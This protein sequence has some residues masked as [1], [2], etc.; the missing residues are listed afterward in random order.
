M[1]SRSDTARKTGNQM[2]GLMKRAERASA[3]Q[4]W[5]T[6]ARAQTRGEI[7]S[8]RT[9]DKGPDK[10][11]H[12][13]PERGSEA[14]THVGRIALHPGEKCEDDRPELGDEVEPLLGLQ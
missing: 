11:G 5:A 1:T 8:G 3:V 10:R 13:N 7:R 9:N 6:K 12:A 14:A 2:F 4:R